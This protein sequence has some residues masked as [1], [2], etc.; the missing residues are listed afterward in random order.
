MHQDLF[1]K[2]PEGKDC[3]KQLGLSSKIKSVTLYPPKFQKSYAGSVCGMVVSLSV[4]LSNLPKAKL[5]NNT[6]HVQKVLRK[7]TLS[8]N[9]VFHLT[10]KY[11]YTCKAVKSE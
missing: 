6:K 10:L 5:L 2:L 8:F 4:F 1:N 9:S 7:L 11:S 3:L